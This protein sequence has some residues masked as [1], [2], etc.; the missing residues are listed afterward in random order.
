MAVSKQQWSEAMQL[1][2][3]FERKV[4]DPSLFS[5]SY[6]V[7]EL[8][9]SK[10]TLWRNSEFKSEHQRIQKLVGKYIT[11]Q[12]DYNLEACKL[13]KKDQEIANLK[14]RI[15]ELEQQ[16]DHERERLVYAVLIARRNNIDPTLFEKE[17]PLVKATQVAA[18]K[19]K[20][21]KDVLD[22]DRFRK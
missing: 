16:L 21:A 3:R 14:A 1:L 2:S 12:A 5:W 17:T 15:I 4:L 20:T 10:A 19:Q 18:Q 11:T 9:I 6:L 8:G 13:S 7:K 22:L